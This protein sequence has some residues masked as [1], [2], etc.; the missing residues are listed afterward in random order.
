MTVST[1]TLSA[2]HPRT[3]AYADLRALPAILMLTAASVMLCLVVVIGSGAA[4]ERAGRDLAPLPGPI[5]Q[6]TLEAA[7]QG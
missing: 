4:A 5:P 1:R 6:P 3:A 7:S 2:P